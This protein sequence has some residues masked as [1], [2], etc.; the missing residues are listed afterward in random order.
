[1]QS[2]ESRKKSISARLKRLPFGAISFFTALAGVLIAVVSIFSNPQPSLSF[3]I[4][5]EV[6]VLNMRAPLEDLRIVFRG[7][8]IQET[9]MNLRIYSLHVIN[10]GDVDI[11]QGDFDQNLKWGFEVKHGEIIGTPKVVSASSKYLKDNLAPR[12]VGKDLVEFPKVIMESRHGFTIEFPVLHS[13]GADVEIVPVG[14]VTGID[15][16]I[17]TMRFSD[18]LAEQS[19]DTYVQYLLVVTVLLAVALMYV[20]YHYRGLANKSK[21]EVEELRSEL[22]KVTVK[23]YQQPSNFEIHDTLKALMEALMKAL[24]S[25]GVQQDLLTRLD[26]EACGPPDDSDDGCSTG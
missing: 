5:S 24:S 21:A 19:T 23:K 7:E 3:E 22:E 16:M 2:E 9:N 10:D 25:D 1:M 11:R 15:H 17:V 6:N 4:L 13:S 8:D 26:E 12:L 20:A 18:K 14:K